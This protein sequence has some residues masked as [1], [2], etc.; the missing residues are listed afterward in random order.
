LQGRLGLRCSHGRT[1]QAQ[2]E[3]Q[4]NSED[5]IPRPFPRSDSP[6][7][8][9]AGMIVMAIRCGWCGCGCGW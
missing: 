5:S 1:A 2:L 8:A 7:L 9:P 3:R 4:D 6:S